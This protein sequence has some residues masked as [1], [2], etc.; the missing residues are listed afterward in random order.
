VLH[1]AG[2]N[3]A[4]TDERIFENVA[5]AQS[6]TSALDRA[7]VRP[8]IV[9]ANSIQVGNG[10]PFGESK[11]TA[12][13]HLD[14]WGRRAGAPVA[15]VHLPNLFGEHGRPHYNS[16]VANFCYEL[17]HGGTPKIVDD[18]LLQLL[19]AQDAVDSMLDLI[20]RRTAG[21][22]RPQGV[23][24]KVSALLEKLESFHRVYAT[25]DIP[26]IAN[27]FDR[28]MFNTYRSFLIPDRYPIHSQ[29]RSDA[30][31]DLFE[32]VRSRGGQSQA[33][34]S[35]TRPGATRGE[36]FH[37]RKVERFLV[38]QGNA[39]IALRRLFHD[40]VVRFA[41]SGD[42]PAMV[43]MPTMWTHSITNTGDAD[44]VTLFWTDEIFDPEHAD[45]YGE[46]VNLSLET[47]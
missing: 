29:I 39:T 32:F 26:D 44:L 19:H 17:A 2:V 25:G 5:I 46:R 14:A 34:C 30:R 41:V 24:L 31:G 9:F 10:T 18:R 40:E 28:A 22:V 45:T 11:Q 21:V 20:D 33:F 3:R 47:A 13:E 1:F 27:R 7:R 6:L 35:F 8:T 43:D 15:D 38:V 36:H 4:E 37:R 16:V 42:K 23:P 12:A